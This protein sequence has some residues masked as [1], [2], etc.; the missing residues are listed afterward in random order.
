[1]SISLFLEWDS[2][3]HENLAAGCRIESVQPSVFASDAEIN[4]VTV[5]IVCS[6]S[7]K[8]IIRAYRDEAR[9]LREYIRLKRL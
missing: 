4:I 6:D 5:T 2:I 8:H 9:A 3:N 1:M 7:N